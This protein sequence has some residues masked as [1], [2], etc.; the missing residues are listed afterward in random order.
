M[1]HAQRDNSVGKPAHAPLGVEASPNSDP[2]LVLRSQPR[3]LK[4][5]FKSAESLLTADEDWM[6]E[7]LD[8]ILTD[9]QVVEEDLKAEIYD[10][11]CKAIIQDIFDKVLGTEEAVGQFI[12]QC[13][14]AGIYYIATKPIH[15]YAK[16][17][18]LF[19]WQ[20]VCDYMGYEIYKGNPTTNDATMKDFICSKGKEGSGETNCGDTQSDPLNCGKCGKQVCDHCMLQFEGC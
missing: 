20:G 3:D 4:T 15:P 16:A 5:W 8:N 6:S 17:A 9:S 1:Y 11:I 13:T 14:L 18:I 10:A 2:W 12:E 7:K 19:F